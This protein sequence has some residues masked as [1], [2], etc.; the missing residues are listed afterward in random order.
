MKTFTPITSTELE[1]TDEQLSQVVGGCGGSRRDCDDDGGRDGWRGNE[2]GGRR[3]GHRESFH[4]HS[5]HDTSC[6][7][8]DSR[9]VDFSIL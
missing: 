7:T 8:H 9:D 3:R 6:S 1:L 4:A 2:C 5:E